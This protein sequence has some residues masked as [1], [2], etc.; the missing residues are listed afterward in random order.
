[1]GASL[2]TLAELY[3]AKGEYLRAEPLHVRA[4]DIQETALGPDHA[5]VAQSLQDLSALRWAMDRVPEAIAGLSRDEDL[6][7]R[8]LASVIA[9]GS[10]AQKSA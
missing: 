9:G 3:R 2:H 1:M 10:E 6:G 4:L 8:R 7:E 5:T